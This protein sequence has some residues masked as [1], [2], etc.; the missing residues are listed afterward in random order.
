MSS[1]LALLVAA[2]Q[3]LT[4]VQSNPSLPPE[5]R[6]Q[7]LSVANNAVAYTQAYLN[8]PAGISPSSEPQFAPTT[9]TISSAVPATSCVANP[10]IVLT[11]NKDSIALDPASHGLQRD[12]KDSAVTL[13]GVFASNCPLVDETSWSFAASPDPGIGDSG[14]V[15][16]GDLKANVSW[17]SWDVQDK[18]SGIQADFYWHEP[19]RIATT[20]TY[21]LRVGTESAWITV[22]AK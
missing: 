7:A 22:V 2:I 19:T 15:A 14:A 12:E 6:D 3:L 5:V 11:T 16:N 10:Q 1:L 13:H 9:P 4:L 17:E 18:D 8:A 21:T 20:T